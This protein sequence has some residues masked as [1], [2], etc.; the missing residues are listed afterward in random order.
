M[1]LRVQKNAGKFLSICTIGGFSRRAQLHEWVNCLCL[2]HGRVL[3]NIWTRIFQIIK[4]G[5]MFHAAPSVLTLSQ[6]I[7]RN[8]ISI[9]CCY[10][11]H[12]SLSAISPQCSRT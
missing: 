10:T 3:P 7:C 4:L 8:F 2:S 6:P 5:T 9:S 1:N 11:W 12:G